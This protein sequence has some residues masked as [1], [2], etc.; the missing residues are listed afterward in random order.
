VA[1]DEEYNDIG[2]V[3]LV[4]DTDSDDENLNVLRGPFSLECNSEEGEEDEEDEEK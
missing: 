2:N 3:S 4:Y 1:S